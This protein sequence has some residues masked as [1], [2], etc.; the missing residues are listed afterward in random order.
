M[1]SLQAIKEQIINLLDPKQLL[2]AQ[3]Q[4]LVEGLS[5]RDLVLAQQVLA[6]GWPGPG[7]QTPR[8]IQKL[9]AEERLASLL[10]L[11]PQAIQRYER[12]SIPKQ[13]L[14][15][16]LADF[17]LRANLYDAHYQG[18]G[19]TADDGQWLLRLFDL[20]IFKLGALQFERIRWQP[21]PS[22]YHMPLEVLNHWPTGTPL[23]AVH[24][25]A[26][27]DLSH[28]ACQASFDQ[29]ATFFATYDGPEAYQAYTCFSWLLYPGL[30]AHLGPE[31]R[32]YQFS[33]F[34]DLL[35]ATSWP[36]MAKSRLLDQ[37]PSHKQG[38]R[39]QVLARDNQSILGAALGYR[40]FAAKEENYG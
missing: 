38:S 8:L 23:L 5:E 39:L 30:L 2:F 29:A 21:D 24:I 28:A 19:L 37:A 36:D 7:D 25:M 16:S 27:T 1:R 33:Q 22:Y 32:I 18:L 11:L 35:G 4:D 31:S 13:I 26:G 3:W 15:D 17:Y 34:F 6:D 20:Q 40:P 12:Q 9:T 14:Q 10:F